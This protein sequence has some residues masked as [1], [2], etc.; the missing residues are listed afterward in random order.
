MRLAHHRTSDGPRLVAHAGDGWVDVAV[1]T[2]DERLRGLGALL[3]GG[4]P[5]RE[6]VATAIAAAPAAAR[7]TDDDLELGPVLDR[8]GR[9]FCIG[10][11]YVDH[12]DELDGSESPWPEVFLRLPTSVTGPFDD[13][14]R[15]AVTGAFDYEGELGVVIGRAGRHV[16]AER[17]LE[18]VFGYVAVN[19]FTARDWQ[20]RGEQWTSGKNFDGTLPVGPHVVTADELDADDLALR[21]R[22]NDREVQSARTSQFIFDLGAQIAFLSS[23]TALRPGDLICTGTPG[24]VGIARSPKLLL[25]AGDVVEVQIEGIGTLR[26][27]V[28]DDGLDPATP[29]WREVAGGRG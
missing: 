2:G 11:N 3:D 23:F 8:P 9:I 13:V 22:V 10:R 7:P 24:G 19:D 18:H 5:A 25:T 16:P 6:A 12:R 15:P 27:R 28:V 29:Y 4:T 20:K 1:A 26:N 21:T 17:A 14:P